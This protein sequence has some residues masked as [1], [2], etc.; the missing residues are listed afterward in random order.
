MSG[1]FHPSTGVT[2][3]IA[4]RS[5]A[6]YKSPY[7]PKYTVNKNVM[8]W[9]FKSASRLGMT[10]AGF[11]GV[12]G[13]FALYFFADVPKVRKDIW[14]KVPVIGQHFVKEVPASD[15]PF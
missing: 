15:N 12:A 14:Q 8:G 3:A 13:F 7:G 6:T 2:P 9:T 11:G 1:E 4:P 10:L 5:Y